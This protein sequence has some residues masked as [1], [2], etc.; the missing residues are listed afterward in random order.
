MKSGD[1][2]IAWK[3]GVIILQEIPLLN[4][5]WNKDCPE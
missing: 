2:L 4:V 5:D 3:K 1:W